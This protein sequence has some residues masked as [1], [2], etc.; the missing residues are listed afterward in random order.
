MEQIPQH[1]PPTGK[2]IQ[3]GCHAFFKN[4]SKRNAAVATSIITP[5]TASEIVFPLFSLSL[6]SPGANPSLT[7]DSLYDFTS[8]FE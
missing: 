5:H 2:S 3:A 1:I 4:P 8:Y 7:Q 6:F